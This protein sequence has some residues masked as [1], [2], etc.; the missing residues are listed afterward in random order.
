MTLSVGLSIDFTI[1]YGVAYL[2][3]P[4]STRAAKVQEAFA[5]V[6]APVA[7]AAFTTFLAGLAMHPGRIIAYKQ[8]S[9]F[10]MIVMPMSWSYATFL[11]QSICVVIG[12][13]KDPAVIA[14]EADGSERNGV[15]KAAEGGE[16]KGRDEIMIKGG[17]ENGE[18]KTAMPTTAEGVHQNSRDNISIL[19]EGCKEDSKGS[20]STNSAEHTAG[21][22]ASEYV[23]SNSGDIEST[24]M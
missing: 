19:T 5:R 3:S 10:L 1:H 2:Y 22:N 20:D 17:G 11:L 9:V 14:A 16:G 6:G 8:F 23:M 15:G 12:P 7:M 24:Y 21:V 18:G 13:F 4:A